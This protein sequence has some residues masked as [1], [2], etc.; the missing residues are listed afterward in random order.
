MPCKELKKQKEKG[1]LPRLSFWEQT[2]RIQ[3]G[4]QSRDPLYEQA[5]L[6]ERDERT[7]EYD[8]NTTTWD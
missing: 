6:R 4:E 8:R 2:P 7:G 3:I 1:L 5:Y